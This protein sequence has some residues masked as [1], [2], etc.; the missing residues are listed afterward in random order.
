MQW[1]VFAGGYLYVLDA[2]E[3]FRC[4]DVVERTVTVAWRREDHNPVVD[5]FVIC[6]IGVQVQVEEVVEGEHGH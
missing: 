2:E 5:G 6:P 4:A 1:D 3:T